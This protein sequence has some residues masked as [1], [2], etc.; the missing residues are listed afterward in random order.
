MLVVKPP[1]VIEG[2]NPRTREVSSKCLH[3]GDGPEWPDIVRDD[4]Y[5]ETAATQGVPFLRIAYPPFCLLWIACPDQ[6][7][8]HRLR[9]ASA[10]VAP[11]QND[12]CV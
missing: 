8:F 5:G 3:F 1:G 7:C 9:L 6:S 2:K 12:L 4:D 11:R 10:L